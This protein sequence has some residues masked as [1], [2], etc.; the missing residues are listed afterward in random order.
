MIA[1]VKV[2]SSTIRVGFL[3]ALIHLVRWPDWQ[4]PVL[5]TR[6]FKVAGDIAPSN[7][8]P[9][10]VSA[11]VESEYSLLDPTEADNW[12]QNLAKDLRP[13]DLDDEVYKTAEEQSGRG[14]L[15]KPMTKAHVDLFF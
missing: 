5:F 6:G 10:V 13:S 3:S 7:V 11:A 15:S 14:L 8:Y 9:R 4:L 12:N 1:E 2:A